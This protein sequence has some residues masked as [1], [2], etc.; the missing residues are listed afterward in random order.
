[1]YIKWKKELDLGN[2]LI[3]TQHRML[4][5]LCRKLDIAIKTHEPETTL[6][7]IIL[8]LKKFAEFHFLSEENLMH[9]IDY[10]E[11]DAHAIIHTGLLR[12]IDSML[13]KINLHRESADELLFFLK[14]WVANHILHED[15]KIAEYITNSHKRPIG[16]SLYSEY[17]LPVKEY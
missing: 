8:E 5:L 13:I 1:M 2:D 12:Q 16:E 3:D 4:V 11:T 10:P 14:E 9:E 6:R 17:L 7:S 15:S